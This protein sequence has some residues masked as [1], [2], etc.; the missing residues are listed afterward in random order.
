METKKGHLL[1]LFF[2]ILIIYGSTIQT[3]GF[4]SDDYTLMMRSKSHFLLSPLESHHYSLPINLLFFGVNK[5][6]FNAPIFHI[7]A[8]LFHGINTSLIY[9]ILKKNLNIKNSYCLLSALFFAVNPA[10]I[11]AIVWCCALPYVLLTTIILSSMKVYFNFIK[12]EISWVNV[13]LLISFLQIF[14]FLI[15]DWA[16]LIF[17]ILF[18]ITLLKRKEI[19]NFLPLICCGILWS[20]I[21]LTKKFFGLSLGYHI[22]TFYQILGTFITSPL[23]TLYPFATKTFY[24]SFPGIIYSFTLFSFFLWASLKDKTIRLF[25]AIFL[26]TILPQAV[27]GYPQSR[28]YYFSSF[29]LYATFPFILMKFRLKPYLPFSFFFL[30]FICS[31]SFT[32]KKIHLWQEASSIVNQTYV[33]IKTLL[34]NHPHSQVTIIDLPDSLEAHEQIWKPFLWRCGL[35][36]FNE[37]IITE[38]KNNL[39]AYRMHG[40]SE[41]YYLEKL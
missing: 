37:K 7:L 9:L 33:E 14:G 31:T 24:L 41:N 8:L 13:C 5:N 21:L 36:V 29:P 3:I 40:Y 32:L 2:L 18:I 23:L 15:W 12:K 27:L 6:L 4:I 28:Y 11:E 30:F 38:V 22:N 34:T 19:N 39:P 10:G 16:I 25:F 26:L 17:P 1:I 35:E 20:L